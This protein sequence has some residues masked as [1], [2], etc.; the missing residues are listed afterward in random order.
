MLVRDSNFNDWIFIVKSGSIKVIKKLVR[1]TSEKMNANGEFR[2]QCTHADVMLAFRGDQPGFNQLVER[3]PTLEFPPALCRHRP[4]SSISDLTLLQD[5]TYIENTPN[6]V[7]TPLPRD[8]TP[9]RCKS[10]FARKASGEATTTR[11]GWQKIRPNLENITGRKR[12]KQKSKLASQK[13]T[14]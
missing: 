11:R 8:E 7:V 14:R 1:V 10:A 2:K 5:N 9:R 3:E 4:Q 13:S 6:D 12:G